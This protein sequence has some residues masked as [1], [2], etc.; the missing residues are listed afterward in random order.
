VNKKLKFLPNQGTNGSPSFKKGLNSFFPNLRGRNFHSG[1]E[2]YCTIQQ[3]QAIQQFTVV[4]FLQI[5]VADNFIPHS[6]NKQFN[7]F[8]LFFPDI[9]ILEVKLYCGTIQQEQ[10]I[11]RHEFSI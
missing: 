9:F 4:F 11:Q 2:P 5:Y 6:K 10:A 3:E 7:G 8:K 1:N